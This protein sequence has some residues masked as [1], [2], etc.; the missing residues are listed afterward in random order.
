MVKVVVGAVVIGVL[1]WVVALGI[2][3]DHEQTT[4]EQSYESLERAAANPG[5]GEPMPDGDA[6][7]L[8]ARYP[9]LSGVMAA[10]AALVIGSVVL[11]AVNSDR[12]P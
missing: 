3:S 12:R 2:R 7:P 8:P 9:F 4:L 11:I 10:L 6:A 5:S 1:A